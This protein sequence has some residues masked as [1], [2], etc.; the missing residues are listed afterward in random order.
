MLYI[1]SQFAGGV[2]DIVFMAD[3]VLFIGYRFARFGEGESAEAVD[4]W[5]RA[6]RRVEVVVCIP[7]AGKLS[8][9]LSGGLSCLRLRAIAGIEGIRRSTASTISGGGGD[10]SESESFT[11]P[12]STSGSVVDFEDT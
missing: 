2:V 1:C 9:T 4:S 11:S 6:D 12:S 10:R 8:D 7:T 5:F 3:V